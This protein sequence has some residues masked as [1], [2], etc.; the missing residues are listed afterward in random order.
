MD[1]PDDRFIKMTYSA[2]MFPNDFYFVLTELYRGSVPK[3]QSRGK[4]T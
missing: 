4:I 2:E 1:S 3:N